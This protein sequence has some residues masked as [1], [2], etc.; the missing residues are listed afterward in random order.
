MLIAGIA[1][2]IGGAGLILLGA[3]ARAGRLTRQSI[4]G[5]RTKTTMASDEAWEAAHAAGAGWV[6][7]AG[8]VLLVGG[9]AV[10]L[11][12]SETAGGVI[13]LI[14]TGVMLLPLAIA[15]TRGQAAARSV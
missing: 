9:V 6:V 12:D 14:A 3:M 11:A 15:F 10:M 13:A 7:A 2:V 5:L 1:M 8:V 4:V